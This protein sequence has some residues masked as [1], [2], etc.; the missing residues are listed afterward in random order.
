MGFSGIMKYL[1]LSEEWSAVLFPHSERKIFCGDTH[2]PRLTG[3][4]EVTAHFHPEYSTFQDAL[5]Q[6]IILINLFIKKNIIEPKFVNP[7]L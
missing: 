1:L 2:Y 6:H 4:T 5:Y 3:L 7:W